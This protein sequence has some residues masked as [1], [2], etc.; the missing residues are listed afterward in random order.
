MD[1]TFNNANSPYKKAFEKYELLNNLSNQNIE[2]TIFNFSKNENKNGRETVKFDNNGDIK[3]KL[4]LTGHPSPRKEPRNGRPSGKIYD[5]VFQEL[6]N[7]KV[8][9]IENTIF[10][11]FKF[12]YFD[13]RDTQ[14]KE[15]PD[16][17]YW[18]EKLYSGG[19]IPVFFH[20][21]ITGKVSS[22]GLSYLYKF[23]YKHSIMD[24]L[25]KNH[26]SSKIDLSEAIFGCIDKKSKSS[27]KGRVSFSHAKAINNPNML[28][29]RYVLLGTPRASYYPIYLVQNGGEYKTLMDDNIVL[30]GRKRYPI[31][32]NFDH[33]CQGQ[34]TQTT[35]ITPLNS[36]IKFKSS[37]RFHNLKKV[38]IGALLSALTFHNTN[39]CY[40]NI[41]M[42]KPLGYGKIEVKI[43]NLKNLKYKFEDY[44]KEFES[45]INAEIFDGKIQW[46]TSEQII[47][48]LTM[49]TPQ[50]NNNLE[51][52]KLIDF[53]KEKNDRNYLHRYIELNGVTVKNC[54][55]LINQEN[56]Q[57]YLNDV[58]IFKEREK[59]REEAKQERAKQDLINKEAQKIKDELKKSSQE[60]NIQIVENFITKYPD[61]EQLEDIKTKLQDIK[62]SIIQDKHSKINSKFDNVLKVLQS[63]K[64]N[65]KQYKKE[66]DKFIKRWGAEK[67]NRKSP[68]I[69]KKLSML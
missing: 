60:V 68:Y 67:N 55:T 50:N 20:T 49:A 13:K 32:R 14:P 40:H 51:Y 45:C 38:E 63:K 57:S 69:L 65:Q 64:G 43:L 52:M 18:K 5:F 6:D 54:A 4:V 24:A 47:N 34:S 62:E 19:K 30:A 9:D 33:Q 42:A 12:A 58:I 25:S 31:H 35:L 44:L 28:D 41:G 26:T 37:I 16:W 11:N 39:D 21:D 7:S 3:G 23:P 61:Y 2:N 8:Y 46:H 17:T 15:S 10:E 53:A 48:L 66:L 27:L 1:G 22:F 36:N 59:Q 29:S 56:L